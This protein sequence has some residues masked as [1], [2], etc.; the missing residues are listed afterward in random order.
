MASRRAQVVLSIL[1]ICLPICSGFAQDRSSNVDELRERGF[2]VATITPVFGQ[3]VGF[4]YPKGFKAAYENVTATSY[5]QEHV[6]E[7]ESA[8]AWTQM[9]T[10]SGSKALA[11]NPQATL[12]AYLQSIAAG[13]RRACPDTFLAK[14]LGTLKIEGHEG[15]AGLAGCGTVS[16]AKPRSE[17]V[18]LLVVKGAE[19]FYS[20]QWA[21]RGVAVN[22][23]PVFDDGLWKQ[24]YQQLSPIRLCARV[25]SE[26][27]PYT[28]C[29][30][31]RDAQFRLNG[32]KPASVPPNNSLQR[33]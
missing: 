23:A 1:G 17:I 8:E 31:S 15:L 3:L 16:S 9:I 30:D 33:P 20:I 6:L 4:S 10:L 26:A 32:E 24:R 29:V 11:T 14:A 2:K 7:G 21:E 12:A 13:I 5:I 27:P 28:S 19:D 18:L 25:P 22:Q